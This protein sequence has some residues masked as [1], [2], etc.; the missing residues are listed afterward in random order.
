LLRLEQ[1]TVTLGRFRL[2]AD[3]GVPRGA[4]VA[5]IGPSGGGKS[6]LLSAIGGYLEPDS[7]RVL[8]DGADITGVPPGERPVTTLF[9]DGNLFPHLTVAQNVGLGLAPR[10]RLP[11]ADRARVGDVLAR[12]G[13]AGLG[14]RRPADLSGGQ[15]SRVALARAL[16]RARPLLLLDEPFAAL[17]PA[18]RVEMLDLVA[19][20]TEATGA[21]LLMVTHAP[22]DALRLCPAT[23]VVADGTA[24]PPTP[25]EAL[26][27]D[28]PQA[29][30]DY[31][32]QP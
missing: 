30:R 23:I 28:P 5:V 22:Q 27:A 2:A 3:L 4:R 24:S 8:W 18:L 7:G 32:G 15:Q 14:A 6:T 13:L 10:L 29:L 11:A 20:V 17:G 1:V 12:T 21:T 26:L 16:L 25:T 9:Q 19:E 31:L